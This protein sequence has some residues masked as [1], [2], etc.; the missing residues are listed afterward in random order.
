VGDSKCHPRVSVALTGAD[1]V[2]G[3]LYNRLRSGFGAPGSLN[4]V[5]KPSFTTPQTG[6][7][8]ETAAANKAV[9]DNNLP[10]Q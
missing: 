3:G 7:T 6:L 10:G 1:G 2:A 9:P 8:P 5:V 4:L